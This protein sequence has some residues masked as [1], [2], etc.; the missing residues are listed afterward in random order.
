MVFD[1]C[2]D[3]AGRL[4]WGK[5]SILKSDPHRYEAANTPSVLGG[6]IHR[7]DHQCAR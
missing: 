6:E 1:L 5:N 3:R 7:H 4:G 2:R